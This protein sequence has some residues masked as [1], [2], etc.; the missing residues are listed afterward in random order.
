MEA[1]GN[2][3]SLSVLAHTAP[4]NDKWHS[5]PTDR[6]SEEAALAARKRQKGHLTAMTALIDIYDGFWV[7]GALQPGMACYKFDT[8]I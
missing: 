6:G 7:S 1:Y 5:S 8:L 2:G 3:R 4:T